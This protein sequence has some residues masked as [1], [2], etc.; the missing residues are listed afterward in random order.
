MRGWVI[1]MG[2]KVSNG[3][4]EW[5]GRSGWALGSWCGHSLHS[6][7]AEL[8]HGLEVWTCFGPHVENCI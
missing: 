7:L 6:S 3:R 5:G 1:E 4:S 2:A 8:H